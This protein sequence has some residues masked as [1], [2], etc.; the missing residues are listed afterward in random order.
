MSTDRIKQENIISF[1]F[2]VSF[3]LLF[4]FMGF[5]QTGVGI[6]TTIPKSDFEVNG[7]FAKKVTIVAE[8]TALNETHSIVVCN[9]A[10][11][12]ITLT[13]PAIS[14]CVGR[15][16]TIK[17]GDSTTNVTIDANSTEEIDGVETMVLSDA[18]IA[19]TLFNNG[20]E[21]QAT[22]NYDAQFPMG[23]VS[24]FDTGGTNIG[25]TLRSNGS[26][27]MVVCR[28]TTTL[29]NRGEFDNGGSNNGRLRYVGKNSKIFHIACTISGTIVSS[30]NKT[31]V[32]G[33]AQNGTVQ[34]SSKV[35]NRFAS[36][37]DVQSTSLHVMLTLAPNDYLE[38]FVGNTTDAIDFKFVSLNLVAI[39]M[40]D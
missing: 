2:M 31:L 19:I 1:V 33:I 40:P 36:E 39:G 38:F 24:Y 3:F 17:K 26:S 7:S 29:L 4:G 30:T 13:L 18:K 14:T 35:L 12:P 25:I 6:N 28:P 27:N 9:N 10:T 23:E 5:A 34:T 11:T 20:M 15:I 22:A 16:Y 32:F 8:N 21:W 37:T